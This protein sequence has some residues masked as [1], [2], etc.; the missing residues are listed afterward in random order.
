MSRLSHKGIESLG[1]R[2]ILDS[3]Y[4]GD[5]YSL[6]KKVKIKGVPEYKQYDLYYSGYK[7][8]IY[9]RNNEVL[10]KGTIKSKEELEKLLEQLEITYRC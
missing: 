10:F 5:T 4:E 3:W 7:V 9:T 1:F 8:N 6:N 2:K